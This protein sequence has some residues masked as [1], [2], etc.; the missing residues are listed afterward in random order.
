MKS[1]SYALYKTK[2]QNYI[3]LRQL[4]EYDEKQIVPAVLIF[5]N[6]GCSFKYISCGMPGGSLTEFKS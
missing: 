4:P 2:D 6:F 5:H 3:F 1:K